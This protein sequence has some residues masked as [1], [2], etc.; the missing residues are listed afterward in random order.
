[1][2]PSKSQRKILLEKFE[3]ASDEMQKARDLIEKYGE[4]ISRLVDYEQ[5][6]LEMK[7]HKKGKNNHFQINGRIIFPGGRVASKEQNINPFVSISEVMEKMATE[8]EHKI[9]RR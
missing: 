4:K 3:L 5:I 8:I 9:R 1:M 7:V 2:K 6:A